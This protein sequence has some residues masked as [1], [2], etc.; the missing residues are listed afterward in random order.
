MS[1]YEDVP[2]KMI[3]RAVCWTIGSKNL[4]KNVTTGHVED[5]KAGSSSA[6]LRRRGQKRMLMRLKFG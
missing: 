6:E 4:R 1:A 5:A 2:E 3:K